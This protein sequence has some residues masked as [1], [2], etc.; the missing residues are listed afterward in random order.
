[1]TPAAVST[2]ARALPPP[3]LPSYQVDTPRPSPRTN[4]TRRA[5]HPVLI[6]HAA[7]LTPYA[8]TQ[9]LERTSVLVT[10]EGVE[11]RFTVA[12]PAAGR[13]ILGQKA[14]HILTDA[15][16]GSP[17]PPYGETITPC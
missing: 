8:L 5:P 3:P 9:V 4:R 17:P 13:S 16:P 12:L 7:S 2:R 1:V 10:P 14:A 15:L 11:A 6:G